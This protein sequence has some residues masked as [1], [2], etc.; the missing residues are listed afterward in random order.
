MATT[1]P[2]QQ[3]RLINVLST[4]LNFT[5]AQIASRL[6]VSKSR[7]R[8]LI[9][10]LRSQ[11]YAIYS[12]RKTLK[13]GTTKNVYVLSNPSRKMVAAAFALAG[14]ELFQ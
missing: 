13:N 2:N 3:T 5:T 7:A 14:A 8:F 1:T 12:N 9:T 11:G 4:G 6:N 10:E